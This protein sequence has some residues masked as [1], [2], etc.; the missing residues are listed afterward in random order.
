MIILDTIMLCPHGKIFKE[1]RF[2]VK[3]ETYL[4]FKIL[5]SQSQSYITTDGQ[6]A[7]LSWCQALIWDPRPIFLLLSSIIFIQLRI[8]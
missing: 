7:S 5:S 2:L 3:C 6:T 8:C 1:T 4:C